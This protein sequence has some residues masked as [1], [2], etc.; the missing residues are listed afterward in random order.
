MLNECIDPKDLF[1]SSVDEFAGV[2]T[3][4]KHTFKIASTAYGCDQ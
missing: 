2:Q 4:S 1:Y 3:K